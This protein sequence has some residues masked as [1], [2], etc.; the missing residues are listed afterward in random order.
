MTAFRLDIELLEDLH[1]GAGVGNRAVDAL[2]ARDAQGRPC[3]FHS[4]LKGVL[5]ESAARLDRLLGG[6][7]A[8]E[9]FGATQ[10]I[11]GGAV[12]LTSAYLDETADR[13][14]D[15]LTWSSGAREQD[16]RRPASDRL[17]IAEFLAAGSRLTARLAV[18]DSFVPSLQEVVTSTDAL[19]G[20]RNRGDG[21]VRLTLQRDIAAKPSSVPIAENSVRVLLRALDPLF[22][23]RTSEPNS[24]LID[25]EPFVRG[26]AVSGALANLAMRIQQ[27]RIA[28]AIWARQ[29]SVSYGWPLID[30][31]ED[32][33]GVIVAPAPL[34]HGLK[35]TAMHSGALPWWSDRIERRLERNGDKPAPEGAAIVSTDS[36]NTWRWYEAPMRGR[37]RIAVPSRALS[38]PTAADQQLF[39]QQEIC[40]W[41]Y[42]LIDVEWAERDNGSDLARAMQALLDSGE[43]WSLGRG[44]RPLEVVRYWPGKPPT[45]KGST[46][47]LIAD[48]LVRDPETLQPQPSLFKPGG[49]TNADIEAKE[50]ATSLH[51]FNGVTRLPRDPVMVIRHGSS[52]RATNG[53]ALP[54]I[55]ASIEYAHEGLNRTIDIELP[56]AIEQREVPAVE[57]RYL[58]DEASRERAWREARELIALP[59]RP[60]RSQIRD[61]WSTVAYAQND[62]DARERL[63][64]HLEQTD[65]RAK[66][67][68]GWHDALVSIDPRACSVDW[69]TLCRL[70]LEWALVLER[71]ARA[72]ADKETT[73]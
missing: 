52:Y 45:T 11:A 15:T 55:P 14:W 3:L 60:S 67:L 48:A 32:L 19:G 72:T 36:G 29:L 9:L 39:L 2:L 35:K 54:S 4:H 57:P 25:G 22:F 53:A 71:D 13:A 38:Q 66:R 27:P 20:D 6:N 68:E 47:L 58:E 34:S 26:S 41:T 24:S 43:W 51:G 1:S 56:V 49:L 8:A 17:G 62:D 10:Q 61:L 46:R 12:A 59:P 31:P 37:L 7:R 16:S 63:R 70:T 64:A 73:P 5:R 30:E 44:G 21:R 42:F 23:P 65:S 50:V 40:E 18:A 69:R 33:R 28:D